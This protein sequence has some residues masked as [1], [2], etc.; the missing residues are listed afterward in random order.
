MKTKPMTIE[1]IRLTISKILIYFKTRKTQISTSAINFSRAKNIGII[2]SRGNKLSEVAMNKIITDLIAENK[3]VIS[4]EYIQKD[5]DS[6]Y[7]LKEKNH[8]SM[9]N[10]DINFFYLPK[11]VITTNFL[12]DPY[13]IIINLSTI[14]LPFLHH[15]VALSQ[16][17]MKVGFVTKQYAHL[18]DFMM[19]PAGT[20]DLMETSSRL[21]NFIKQ[22]NKN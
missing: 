11:K 16:S 5:N 17:R 14:D 2:Y 18:Y 3:K 8:F 9:R 21:I 20:R 13:D 12:S 10:E 15:I 7:K 22:I 6:D 4:L 19:D 1:S